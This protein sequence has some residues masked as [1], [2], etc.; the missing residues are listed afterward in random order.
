MP[1]KS[2]APTRLFGALKPFLFVPLDFDFPGSTNSL[3]EDVPS[4]NLEGFNLLGSG[5]LYRSEEVSYQ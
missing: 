1:F 5:F 4:C 2:A 3:V